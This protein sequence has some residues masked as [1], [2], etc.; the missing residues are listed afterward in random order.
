MHSPD[1]FPMLGSEDGAEGAAAFDLLADPVLPLEHVERAVRHLDGLLARH[2]DQAGLVPDDPV[3]GMDLLPAAHDLAPNLAEALR[4]PGV[5]GHVPTEAREI[6]LENRIEVPHRAVD[7]DAGHALHDA[8]VRC[9]LA[10]DRGRPAARPPAL[11]TAPPTMT[12]EA[13]AFRAWPTVSEFKPPATATG[14]E[15]AAAT[16]LSSP[17]GV[18]AIICSSIDTCMFR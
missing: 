3:A 18:C 1:L 7:H 11:M 17:S 14:S 13:P 2:D 10:P 8:R 9:E 16:A 6:Q 15:V 12:I 5:R 4:F